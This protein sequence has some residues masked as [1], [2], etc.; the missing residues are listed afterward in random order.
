M[1]LQTLNQH[2]YIDP[3]SLCS[4]EASLRGKANCSSIKGLSEELKPRGKTWGHPKKTRKK[5]E[6]YIQAKVMK[7]KIKMKNG[8]MFGKKITV[9]IFKHTGLC[10]VYF[11][12]SQYSDLKKRNSTLHG[13]HWLFLKYINIAY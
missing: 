3:V 13:N 11:S 8:A 4:L 7:D 2:N 9:V 10:V 5:I 12:M 1:G 6:K